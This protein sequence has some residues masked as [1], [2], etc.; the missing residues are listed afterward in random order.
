MRHE[1][2]AGRDDALQQPLMIAGRIDRGMALVDDA[3]MIEIGADLAALLGARDDMA[4]NFQPLGLGSDA[5]GQLLVSAGRMRGVEA[6]DDAEIAVDPL[7]ADEIADIAQ[8]IPAFLHDRE[9]A[10]PAMAAGELIE[11][12]LHAGRNLAAIAGAAAEARRLGIEDHSMAPAPRRLK[13]GLQASIAGADDD[14]LGLLRRVGVRQIRP[15]HLVPPIRR[16]LEITGEQIARHYRVIPPDQIR[17]TTL[18]SLQ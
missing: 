2:G 10:L 14:D 15:G 6:A 16:C 5:A 1:F 11:A 9:G 13:R 3:T 4:G 17:A 12:R 8:R 18:L 7:V